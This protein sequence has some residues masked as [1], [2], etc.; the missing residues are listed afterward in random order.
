MMM[1]ES[2]KK[3]KAFFGILYLIT[4]LAAMI[5]LTCY[6]LMEGGMI[7]DWLNAL[8]AGETGNLCYRF[9]LLLYKISGSPVFTYTCYM[10]L[11]QLGTLAGS[12]FL[13]Y[14]LFSENLPVFFGV[15]LYMTCPWRIFVCYDRADL[16]LAGAFMLLPFLT[17]G[18]VAVVIRRKFFA[19]LLAF[20][21]AAAGIM[22]FM[23]PFSSFPG[24]GYRPGEFFTTFAYREG[25]PGLGL[26]L[27]V[28][29]LCA[30]W[31][32]YVSGEWEKSAICLCFAVLSLVCMAGALRYSL[33]LGLASLFF[34]VPGAFAMSRITKQKNRAAGAGIP[35]FVFFLCIMQNV[36]LCNMLVYVRKPL[37]L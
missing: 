20:L 3:E 11:I 19:G 35:V 31:L 5:P 10:V 17:G 14:Q 7:T 4:L 6:Y 1:T 24:S 22:G 25:H 32:K 13:F 23:R 15:L 36:Y 27:I 37:V 16:P 21:I 33:F 26:G 30:L 28:C 29:L 18:I 8:Q 9:S 34:C 2:R 12:Y